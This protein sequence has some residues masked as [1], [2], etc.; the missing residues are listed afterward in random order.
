MEGGFL[1]P[2]KLPGAIYTFGHQALWVLCLFLSAA[3]FAKR[4]TV[5]DFEGDVIEGE[6]KTPDLFIQ[7][8][9]DQQDTKGVI[10][11]RRN[12]NDFHVLD[13]KR[14]PLYLPFGGASRPATQA[15]PPAQPG[16]LPP[17][18]PP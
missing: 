4:E 2:R 5:L 16:S 13:S 12:F 1:T 9:T 15:R 14:R 6:R 18:V 11:K 3:V 17:R 10:F 7:L 8:E